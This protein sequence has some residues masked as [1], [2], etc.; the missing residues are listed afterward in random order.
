[1]PN[2]ILLAEDDNE[3]ATILKEILKKN[4]YEVIVATDGLQ[5]TNLTHKEKPNLIILDLGM[6]AG[7]GLTALKNLK[8]SVYTQDIPV[9][10]LTGTGGP[11]DERIAH[12]L[13]VNLYLRKPYDAKELLVKIKEFLSGT[14]DETT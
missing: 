12:D 4:G 2:K 5:A 9:I 8:M 6:P 3:L 13:G 7:G 11:Q 14:S 1:M 10:I